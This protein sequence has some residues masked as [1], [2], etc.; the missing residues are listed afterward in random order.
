MSDLFG[1]KWAT[2]GITADFILPDDGAH[3]SRVSFDRACTV[4]LLDE[5]PLSTEETDT[6]SEGHISEHFAYRLEGAA[7]ARLSAIRIGI[8]FPLL[9]DSAKRLRSVARPGH[10]ART[11]RRH[12]R[13]P[14]F[15]GEI[16]S[17]RDAPSVFQRAWPRR[18]RSDVGSIGGG[19]KFRM[20]PPK[21]PASHSPN[22]VRRRRQRPARPARRVVSPAPGDHNS[23]PPHKAPEPAP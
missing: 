4:R 1:F 19:M 3:L 23:P 17:I 21:L 11:V 20:S 8:P 5:M 9:P 14:L 6:P 15:T 2:N 13:Q 10:H 22:K 12:A 7:F 16:G 18:S